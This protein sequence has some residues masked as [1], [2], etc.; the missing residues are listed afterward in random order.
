MQTNFQE[1]EVNVRFRYTSEVFEGDPNDVYELAELER[2]TAVTAIE[3]AFP[4][5][6][7]FDLT[8]DPV[9]GE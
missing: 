2:A 8:V 7:L 6:E 1:Y 3:I 9:I 4:E 5:A